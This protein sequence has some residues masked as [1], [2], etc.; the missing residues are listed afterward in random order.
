MYQG[1][2][3]TAEGPAGTG[4]TETAKDFYRHCGRHT[5]VINCSDQITSDTVQKILTAASSS[6]VVFDEYNRLT[7]ENQAG[8]LE[9]FKKF[10]KHQTGLAL[11]FNPNFAGRI[12]V[13]PAYY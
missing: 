6:S 13:T 9:H 11:T 4:K 10:M 7:A 1:A 12:A 2:G 5:V 3:I 8:A